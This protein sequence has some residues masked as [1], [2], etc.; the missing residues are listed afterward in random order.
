MNP[1]VVDGQIHGGVAQGIGSALL[2]ELIYDETGQLIT[3]TFM[4][5]RLPT[6]MEVPP[7]EIIHISSPGANRLGVKGM[8]ESGA[9]GP[10]A[11]IA[12]AVADAIGPELASRVDVTPLVPSRVWQILQGSVS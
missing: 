7:V 5:Y 4:D 2:E 11:A 1:L 10:M 3:T 9:I 6:T 12:N 8:G